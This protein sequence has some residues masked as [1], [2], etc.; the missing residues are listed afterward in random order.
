MESQT[1]ILAVDDEASNLAI[2]NVHFAK[3]GYQMLPAQDGMIALQ[4]LEENPGIA[5]IVLDKTMPN[6][7]GMEFLQ[8]IKADARFTHMPVVML[9]GAATVEA[10]IEGIAAGVR[11]YLTKPYSGAMLIE[12]VN[13]ALQEVR[14]IQSLKEELHDFSLG[15]G[16]MRQARFHFRTLDEATNLAYKIA[17]C[18][19][20]PQKAAFGLNELMRN[21]VEHGNLGIGYDEK[22]NLLRSGS[23]Q[24][25]VERRLNSSENNGKFASLTFETTD[26][27]VIIRIKDQGKG[28]DWQRY[29]DFAP[30]RA[31]AP[32]GRGIASCRALSFPSLEYLGGGNEARCSVPLR[33]DYNQP[34][35]DPD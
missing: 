20:R 30:E 16:L 9:T 6:L 25:E 26:D 1:K 8:K 27:A 31:A 33:E 10:A 23:W 24:D 3:A 5:A 17:T 11:Y 12:I 28:F 34:F 2:M 35:I 4:K 14:N 13:L 7:G 29:L 32:H 19:P 18:F 22:A 15:L 21:A